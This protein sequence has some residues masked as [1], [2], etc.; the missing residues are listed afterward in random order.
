MTDRTGVTNSAGLDDAIELAV[1]AHRGQ[2]DKAGV[3][4]IL[5]PL[6]VMLRM[7][8]E[9]EMTAAVLHDVVEDTHYTLEDLGRAGYPARVLEAVDCLTR[10]EGE[11]YEAFIERVMPNPIAR[12]VKIADIED[13]MDL[14]RID[15]PGDKDLER[16]R[17]YRRAWAVLTGETPPQDT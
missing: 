2:K 15:N 5:H 17:R 6:R 10:R 3:P 1:R 9:E 12:R 7:R 8:T 13:N 11:T 14:R 4:Y 16:W